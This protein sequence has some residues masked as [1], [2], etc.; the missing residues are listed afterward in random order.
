MSSLTGEKRSCYCGEVRSSHT[1]QDVVLKGW[2]HRRRDHGGVIFVDLRDRTGVCQV[3]LSPETI[4][5]DQ[6]KGADI[7][8]IAER[9]AADKEHQIKAVV[10]VHNETATGMVLPIDQVRRAIDEAKHPA[11]LLS[12][13]ISSLASMEY[14]MDA[15]GID[16]TVGGSQKPEVG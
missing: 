13:T 15:W 6:R 5:A 16:L 9:L 7:A 1:G 3:V 14:R 4:P 2:I 12:D 11:L 10:T 8:R